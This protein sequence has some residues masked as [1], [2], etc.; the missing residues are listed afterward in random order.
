[1]P[2]IPTLLMMIA[3]TFCWQDLSIGFV[4][5]AL[6]LDNK[7]PLIMKDDHIAGLENIY[8]PPDPSTLDSINLIENCRICLAECNEQ[9]YCKCSG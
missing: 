1:M 2:L 7:S 6:V 3:K 9:P 4:C 8:V 5:G